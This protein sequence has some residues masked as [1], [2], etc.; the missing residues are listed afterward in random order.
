MLVALTGTPGTGKSSASIVLSERGYKVT[1]VEELAKKHD[2]GM[3]E[4]GC[5]VVDIE[6]LSDCIS[7]MPERDLLI[8]GHLAHHLPNDICIVL[9]AHP[10]LIIKRLKERGYDEETT[11]ANTE[12]EAIDVILVEALENCDSVFEVDVGRMSPEQVADAIEVIM[13]GRGEDFR[14]GKVDW[15]QVVMDWY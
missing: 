15:S 1:T 12:A 7:D 4:E 13:D 2:A 14:P 6:A 5:L 9:R 10:D 8:E 11:M 3:R